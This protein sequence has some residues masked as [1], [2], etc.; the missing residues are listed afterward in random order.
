MRL[1]VYN[2]FKECHY[3]R[4]EGGCMAM[5]PT[6][7]GEPAVL[8]KVRRKPAELPK[9]KK[10]QETEELGYFARFVANKAAEWTAVPTTPSLDGVT[11]KPINGNWSGLLHDMARFLI[12]EKAEL[13]NNE[14][15]INNVSNIVKQVL[16]AIGTVHANANQSP[17]LDDPEFVRH[18]AANIIK[19]FSAHAKII[20]NPEKKLD[21]E[22]KADSDQGIALRNELKAIFNEI[23]VCAGL[24]EK[25][26]E[27]LPY[28]IKQL[29][30]PDLH[31]QVAQ[32]I[33]RMFATVEVG[34]VEVPTINREGLEQ[35]FIDGAINMLVIQKK[36]AAKSQDPILDQNE[37]AAKL[38]DDLVDKN[39]LKKLR[40]GDLDFSYSFL[41]SKKNQHFLNEVLNKILVEPEKD[42]PDF[43]E[44]HEAWKYIENQLKMAIKGILAIVLTPHKDQTALDRRNTLLIGILDRL[45]DH[46]AAL[47]TQSV[48]I[49]GMNRVELEKYLQA[50]HMAS[51]KEPYSERA[52]KL[53]GR[54]DI[55][56]ESEAKELINA[57]WKDKIDQKEPSR[58]ELVAMLEKWEE[59]R[60]GNANWK[61]AYSD[62]AKELLERKNLN[63]EGEARLLLKKRAYTAIA[64]T[65]LKDELVPA[66]FADFIPKFIKPE[67]LFQ[68]VYEIIG[69]T[70]L[71][72]HEQQQRLEL[73][74]KEA[75]NFI[76]NSTIPKLSPFVK[77][78]M[79]A[80]TVTIE[81]Q[82][83]KNKIDLGNGKFLN[84]MICHLLKE[85][86][87]D[88]IESDLAESGDLSKKPVNGQQFIK[89]EVI[90]LTKNVIMIAI[91]E[92][93]ESN[94]NKD[95]PQA[96]AFTNLANNFVKN[97]FEGLK[98]IT[99]TCNELKQ[100]SLLDKKAEV[101]KQAAELGI[102]N[103][104]VETTDEKLLEQYRGLQVKSLARDLTKHLIPKELFN[105]LLPPTL[106]E[107]GL[108][109][110]VTDEMIA[111]YLEGISQT[112]DTFQ[113]GADNKEAKQLKLM[114]ENDQPHPL[115]PL[116]KQMAGK[117]IDFVT[118]INFSKLLR[119][120]A[121]SKLNKVDF[122][123]LD[124][125]FGKA[126]REGGQITALIEEVF[127]PFI[128][129]ILALKLNPKDDK[130]TSQEIAT[131]LIWSILE[132]TH[133]CYERIDAIRGENKDL[134]ALKNEFKGSDE[135]NEKKLEQTLD[136]Y[137]SEKK[138]K[139]DAAVILEDK[140]FYI[141]L[142]IHQEMKSTLK[143][144]LDEL[145][146]EDMWNLYVPKQFET[147]ITRDKIADLLLEYLKEGYDHSVNMKKM[148]AEGKIHLAKEKIEHD[149]A[150][151]KT[152]KKVET[153][154]EF[155]E[156][157][158]KTI[159]EDASKP[160]KGDEASTEWMRGVI[161]KL[162]AKQEAS[163]SKLLTRFSNNAAYAILGK[164]LSGGISSFVKTS[165]KPDTAEVKV[166]QQCNTF[167][168]ITVE[169]VNL[170]LKKDNLKKDE[171]VEKLS[172]K[173]EL[174]DRD[175]KFKVTVKDSATGKA[176]EVFVDA[177]EFIF[178]EASYQTNKKLVA[179]LMGKVS[180]L[181]PTIRRD[182]KKLNKLTLESKCSDYPQITPAN[183]KG[184]L[185]LG[186]GVLDEKEV[187]E[188]LPKN[189]EMQDGHIGFKVTIKDTE[190]NTSREAFIYASEF[191][192]WEAAYGAIN[193]LITDDDWK[194]LIPKLL[195]PL[196][197]KE[198][199]ADF[200]VPYVHALH[201]VQEPLQRKAEAGKA[202]IDKLAAKDP[203]LL[204]F[205]DKMIFKKI[206]K[207]LDDMAKDP[208]KLVK[209]ELP[210]AI[211]I[212]A[213]E[214]LKEDTNPHI[215]ELKKALAERVV[216]LF[217]NEL[218]TPQAP[219]YAVHEPTIG[220]AA[221]NIMSKV[222]DLVQ[223]YQKL[224]KG[225][226]EELKTMPRALAQ[227]LLDTVL[228]TSGGKEPL[229]T[230]DEI[231]TGKF[232]DIVSRDEIINEIEKKLIEVLH[233]VDVVKGKQER[234]MAR[235]KELDQ[236]SGFSRGGGLEEMVNTICKSIDETID[237]FA[238][239]KEKIIETQP[240]L[241]NDIAKLAFRDPNVSTV[242]KE[243][244]HALVAI[245]ISRLF[246]ARPGQEAQ[247]LFE[248]M[249]RLFES[250][251]P[252]NPKATALAWVKELLPEKPTDLLK[253]IVPP[254]L[255]DVLTHEF[256]AE[257][258]EEYVV[259]VK[260]VV[261]TIKSAP[262][263]DQEVKTLQKFVKDTLVKFK[264]PKNAREGLS[265]FEGF[266]R[267][268]E[269]AFMGLLSE[270]KE[271]A[272]F[273]NAGSIVENFLNGSIA[274]VMNGDRMLKL[275]NKQFLADA[276]ID[277]LPTLGD[278]NAKKN[279]SGYPELKP[280]QLVDL[281]EKGL[282][283]LGLDL[284]QF[285]DE[286]KD[287]FKQR[288]QNKYF[289]LQCGVIA[290]ELAFPNGAKDLPIPKVA[291]E[292]VLP[293]IQEAI[294]G[295]IGRIVD[296]NER[297]LF[298]IDFLGVEDENNK[299]VFAEEKKKLYALED[300]L[301][302]TRK[303]TGNEE[304]AAEKLFKDRLHTFAMKTVEQSIPSTWINPFRWL[305]VNFTK[306]IVKMALAFGVSK[307]VWNFISNE[308]NDE[309]FRV[310]I[311]KFLTFAKQY[312]PKK[313][314]K[315]EIE[316]DTEKLK[317][318]FVKG[319]ENLDLLSGIRPTAASGVAGFFTGKSFVELIA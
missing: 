266:V 107:S 28:A 261:D 26:K 15:L 166:G 270:D 129:S 171:T 226:K 248:V 204:T 197:T 72:F 85:K 186:K 108:W 97:A 208:K 216:Y 43:T 9:P 52:E 120:E 137:R 38:V 106:R 124:E 249:T 110:S 11:V 217:A 33:Y 150:L 221:D 95:C 188:T 54:K 25:N 149:A 316:K 319:F 57:A 12:V 292:A 164:L 98:E 195:H 265:G 70:A 84:E 55:S 244:A 17:K 179:D 279:L 173:F 256:I 198:A 227:A 286:T 233:S 87:P 160:V 269:M 251:D 78:L 299:Q 104:K 42:A 263:A 254:F 19:I 172:E 302:A 280:E 236:K 305:A 185:S 51:T 274:K 178:W 100:K 48:K 183:V 293:K 219:K 212:F 148:V 303:L 21:P 114:S 167:P 86:K 99:K 232:K 136:A 205:I 60:K 5:D 276:L 176:R 154:Q 235:I 61:G 281:S 259:E 74:G 143:Q 152:D 3:H 159:L 66:K 94:T 46:T 29:L 73:M 147:M 196:A 291:K 243:S 307:Q 101:E 141:W 135:L 238:Y 23:L 8:P 151:P 142:K 91:K 109:E 262:A 187:V 258:L 278:V 128:E 102:K 246:L 81:D 47:R 200:A 134:A 184:Y 45:S 275:R 202:R 182:F 229:K 16:Y 228:P 245:C 158:V 257:L 35:M 225:K 318:A 192:Y 126:F 105:S 69:E 242:I 295:Q 145:I 1:K 272:K 93:I 285:P 20:N 117:A 123:I 155:I 170:Y 301:K 65:V 203:E 211:D 310:A 138:I 294:G 237:E 24:D 315:E 139:D 297:I 40:G 223:T 277:V 113:A 90:S 255:Q 7:G 133:A 201:K 206:D 30:Y 271:W 267:T 71:E 34:E 62:K 264:D 118:D 283:K 273:K 282:K 165:E 177:K 194:E 193:S 290:S 31:V 119:Q 253:E 115:K 63:W 116:I 213:K 174:K 153:L 252:A 309:K 314:D 218:L 300:H 191:I 268:L 298:A 313:K 6:I 111:P 13:G 82:A 180:K 157:K 37:G 4:I 247:H 112:L 49:D 168:Q 92:A 250:Y 163:P 127:P 222:S 67:T 311:W 131:E 140:E 18:I 50:M 121:D 230:W 39:I 10:A 209:E 190:K 14:P 77:A 317:E 162:M 210:E 79:S 2:N 88:L 220:L 308:K 215:A 161:G 130:Q 83:E 287:A 241:V 231:F 207:T 234:A 125:L 199:I 240:L 189:F 122:K 144:L 312:E 58:A 296:R 76:A 175:T 75:E 132:T 32:G 89:Q 103:L 68:E 80:A 169:N 27:N 59:V 41:K 36:L 156:K 224:N 289:E 284:K 44:I 214:V 96:Q 22:A 288:V 53:W 260:E 56:W 146:P 64:Q 181:I 304:K 306:V 239:K